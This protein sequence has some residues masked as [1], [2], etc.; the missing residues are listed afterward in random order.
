MDERRPAWAWLFFAQLALVI[1]ATVLATRG[2]LPTA[3]FRPP[4]DKL[5]HFGAY[6]LLSFFAVTFFGHR[7]RWRVVGAL[8]V[9]A[10]LEEISQ[11][12]FPTRTFDLGDLTMN[13]AGISVL[14]ALAAALGAA[15]RRPRP[16]EPLREPA[17]VAPL[18]PSSEPP[19]VDVALA[20]QC[21]EEQRLRA[22]VVSAEH[23]LAHVRA[24]VRHVE[25]ELG[26]FGWC[27]GM[28]VLLF[29]CG[30]CFFCCTLSMS[31]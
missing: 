3:L 23:E 1:A 15:R 16:V 8:L 13:A 24:R 17:P 29:F 25:P 12:A 11:R 14:G 22:E 18:Q 19:S 30:S 27:M 26:A 10:T 2:G 28:M 4:V 20:R 7:R 21:G 9:T 5:G 31:R 6:G